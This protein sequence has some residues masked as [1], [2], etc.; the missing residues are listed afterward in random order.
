MILGLRL[1]EEG[2]NLD[3]VTTRYGIDPLECFG[4]QIALLT[5]QG[6]LEFTNNHLAIRLTPRGRLLGNQVFYHFLR[7]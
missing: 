2:V 1:T 4:S 6:L 3:D 7:D 5:K